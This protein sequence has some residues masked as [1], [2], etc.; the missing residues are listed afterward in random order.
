LVSAQRNGNAE[1]GAGNGNFGKRS[2]LLNSRRRGRM[3]TKNC[4]PLAA[5]GAATAA[6]RKQKNWRP[7]CAGRQKPNPVEKNAKLAPGAC[8]Q[9]SV[10]LF[11]FTMMTKAGGNTKSPVCGL[12]I[13]FMALV[14]QGRYQGCATSNW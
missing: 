13:F 4:P 9:M 12:C 7:A 8:Q 14:K 1:R 5:F 10:G 3:Q 6:T 2:S 11:A